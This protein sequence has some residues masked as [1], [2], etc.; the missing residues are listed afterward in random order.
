M[1]SKKETTTKDPAQD[2]EKIYTDAE[3]VIVARMNGH[4]DN[5]LYIFA[6]VRTLQD[7]RVGE[8]PEATIERRKKIIDE[9]DALVNNILADRNKEK[10]TYTQ[11]MFEEFINTHIDLAEYQFLTTIPDSINKGGW[12]FFSGLLDPLN[13]GI[14]FGLSAKIPQK[15]NWKSGR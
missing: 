12:G 15:S 1:A 14:N 5:D 6:R 7:P 9:V 11:A 3:A 8:I 4:I 2:S 10:K 13:Q